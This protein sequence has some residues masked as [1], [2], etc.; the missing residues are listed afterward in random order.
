MKKQLIILVLLFLLG[1]LHAEGFYRTRSNRYIADIAFSGN[2]IVVLENN[3]RTST[4][5]LLDLEGNRLSETSFQQHF[6]ELYI[7]CFGNLLLMNQDSCLQVVFDTQWEVQPVTTFSKKQFYDKVAKF[8]L[9]FNG[10]YV[11]RNMVYDKHDY[12]VQEFHGQ[13][14][15]YSY[16]LKNDTEKKARP[17]CRFIDIEAVKMCQAH[18]NQIIAMYNHA[19][20]LDA[21]NAAYPH[22]YER[23]KATYPDL[24]EQECDLLVLNFLNFRIKEEAEILDLSQNTVM[25]YRSNLLKKVGKDPIAGLV[26]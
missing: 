6:E 24:S 21:F 26:G 22:A 16:I 10:A 11:L 15:T 25:K 17:L 12:H 8:V 2:Q 3:N 5:C 14:Q 7:D 23:L 18:L 19:V 13:T 4:L 9:E 1:S 20:P